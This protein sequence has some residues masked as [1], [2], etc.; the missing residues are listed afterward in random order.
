MAKPRPALTQTTNPNSN[1]YELTVQAQSLIAALIESGGELTPAL[2]A[3]LV[4]NETAIARK[5]DGYVYIEDQIEAQCALLKRK[6]DGLRAI[7]KGLESAQDRLR[8]N[9]KNA[10]TALQKTE[11]PGDEFTYKLTKGGTKLIIDNERVIPEDFKVSVVMTNVDKDRLEQVLK[12]GMEVP[13][14]RI[15]DVQRLVTKSNG[16]KE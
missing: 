12:A 1:L 16:G 15:E 2:E 14:A 11:L 8:T 3:Q 10:M 13:G 4:A 7:R 6:E 9:I 5:I